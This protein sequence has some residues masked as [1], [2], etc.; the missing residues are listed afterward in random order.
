MGASRLKSGLTAKPE[1]TPLLSTPC[2]SLYTKRQPHEPSFF[3]QFPFGGAA[4][5]R[6]LATYPGLFPVSLLL[7]FVFSDFRLAL[8]GRVLADARRVV[9]G[10]EVI[11]AGHAGPDGGTLSAEET[12][13]AG[14]F[15]ETP[16]RCGR[17]FTETSFELLDS[18]LA[19][20]EFSE[21]RNVALVFVGEFSS[22]VIK[23]WVC[24]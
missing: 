5:P 10:E 12:I 20:S 3:P 9:E 21:Y 14:H 4:P 7:R 6:E 13:G 16:V 22:D 23:L 1:Q 2:V 15:G 8:G 19:G 18:L 17:Q 24:I 11:C